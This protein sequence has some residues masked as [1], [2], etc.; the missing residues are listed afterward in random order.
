MSTFVANSLNEPINL[1][2]T[3][4]FG[5]LGERAVLAGSAVV[6][7]A[8]LAL[9]AAHVITDFLEQFSGRRFNGESVECE[10]VGAAKGF[11]RDSVRKFRPCA[12]GT[13]FA[14]KSGELSLERTET[15]A[16]STQARGCNFSLRIRRTY[17][18]LVC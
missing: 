16:L 18:H 2:S 1:V 14:R 3:P 4:I 9:T 13:R 8:Y 6:I 12:V 11:A 7:A 17:A 10:G 5:R 15:E